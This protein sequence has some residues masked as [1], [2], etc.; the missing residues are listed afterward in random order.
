MD[1]NVDFKFYPKKYHR[2]LYFRYFSKKSIADTYTFGT[3]RRYSMLSVLCQKSIAT[4]YTLGKKV[5]PISI[6]LI[7]SQKI[8]A[9]DLY[10]R[11]FYQMHWVPGYFEYLYR[12]YFGTADIAVAPSYDKGSWLI[13]YFSISPFAIDWQ[14]SCFAFF[15]ILYHC[16][17]YLSLEES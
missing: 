17:Y 15:S 7:L 3:L 8:T 6:L 1:V 9:G 5:P 16:E 10:F 14:L 12:Q 13:Y 4:H 2:Y 11:Y